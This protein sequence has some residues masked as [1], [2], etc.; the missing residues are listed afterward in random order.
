MDAGPNL[1]AILFMPSYIHSVLL[2]NSVSV[3]PNVQL[4]IVS[5]PISLGS[6]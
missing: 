3:L 1:S 5:V 4:A 2:E 6:R